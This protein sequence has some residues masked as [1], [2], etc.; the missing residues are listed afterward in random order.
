LHRISYRASFLPV[1]VVQSELE[2]AE[3]AAAEIPGKAERKSILREKEVRQ[4]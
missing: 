2:A 1:T 3:N 4:P